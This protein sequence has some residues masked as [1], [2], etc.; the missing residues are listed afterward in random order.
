MGPVPGGDVEEDDVGVDVVGVYT[1]AVDFREALCEFL[2]VLVV[3]VEAFDHV[4][5][6]VDAGGSDDAYL[7]HSGAEHL[8]PASGSGDEVFAA[9][10]DAADGAG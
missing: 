7:S 2:G 8:A 5:E 4:V 10:D 1:D 9:D 3:F 6:G